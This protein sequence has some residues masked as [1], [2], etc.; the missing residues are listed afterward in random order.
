PARSMSAGAWGSCGSADPRDHRVDVS[1]LICP[2]CA[3]SSH[4]AVLHEDGH[5]SLV[6]TADRG[7]GDAPEIIRYTAEPGGY[8]LEVRDSKNRESNFQDPYQLTVRRAASHGSARTMTLR[9]SANLAPIA[10]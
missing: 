5:S 1:R 8:F 10:I 2:S 9:P 4:L 7:K 3:F 6:Q